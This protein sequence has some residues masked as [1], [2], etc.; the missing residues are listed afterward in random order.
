MKQSIDTESAEGGSLS[1]ATKSRDTSPVK[2]T[3]HKNNKY[4]A[5]DAGPSQAEQRF[6][7]K[8]KGVKKEQK[9]VYTKDGQD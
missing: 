2:G 4:Y 5:L 7:D 8:L 6:V 3:R 1:L 9:L